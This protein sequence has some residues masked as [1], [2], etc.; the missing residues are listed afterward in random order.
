MDGMAD[1]EVGRAQGTAPHGASVGATEGLLSFDPDL[2]VGLVTG[3]A[4]ALLGLSRT[5]RQARGLHE[6]LEA[7]PRLDRDAVAALLAACLGATLPG[8]AEVEDLRLPGAPGLRFSIRR[9]SSGSWMMA[10]A[11]ETL[12]A[13]GVAGLD[14]LT[15]LADRAMF[16][17]RL[18]AALDRPPRRRSGGAVLL[19]DIEGIRAVNQVLGHA[20]GEDLLRA[21]ARRLQAAV[22]DAD[23]VARLAGEEFAVLQSEVDDPERA[24][25]LGGRLVEL[26]GKPYLIAGEIVVVTPRVGIAVAPADGDSAAEL[27]RRAAMARNET[28]TEGA[29]GFRRFSPEMDRRWQE[30]RALEAALR[31]AVADNAF[32][33][34]F[35][36]QVALPDERLTGFEALIRWRHPE[37]GLLAPAVFL[38][39]AERLGLM[40][41]IGTWVLHEACR[42]AAAW[43]DPLTV[44]VNIAPAQLEHGSLPEDVAAALSAAGLPAAR[45][46][47]EV[48]E[49]VLLATADAALRQL[50][51]LR[52]AGVRFAMDDFGTGHSSLT[53]LRLF[54]FDRLKIDRSFVQDLPAGGDAA[55]IVR[56]VAGLGR[57]LGIAVTAEGVETAEQLERLRAE[58]C[59]AAQGYL[60]G[61]P[62]P[63]SRIPAMIAAVAAR[64]AATRDAS[65]EAAVGA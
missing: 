26:L 38:P 49:S 22:R 56:A 46:E 4:I 54:P 9:A 17:A 8:G 44:A 48:T 42:L 30:Q 15:G 20:I 34:H 36:P 59:D 41:R 57:S 14:P 50:L 64:G 16:V 37:R 29:G 21:A 3:R 23:L 52:D 55:A 65:L 7:S 53:Q 5:G 6:L 35:Q 61:R 47:L 39:V 60:F 33:L 13:N 12:L 43:P 62:E 51:E 58:G 2:H 11:A 63:P 28:A 32:E 40:R 24:A 25:A 10:M 1:A 19:C 18:A 27:L 31:Q 45:L